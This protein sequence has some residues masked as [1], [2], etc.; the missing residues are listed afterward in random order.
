MVVPVPSNVNPPFEIT[1][2]KVRVPVAL[3]VIVW[4]DPD[5][6]TDAAQP[7]LPVPVR[8]KLSVTVMDVTAKF[9]VPD[10]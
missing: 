8:V 5:K 6:F 2:L 3:F 9:M 10:D 4:T 1:P 7:E